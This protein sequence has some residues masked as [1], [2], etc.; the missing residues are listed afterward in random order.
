MCPRE[1]DPVATAT[2][3]CAVCGGVIGVYEPLIHV[4]SGIA[5]RTSRAA[6]PELARTQPGACYHVGCSH[7]SDGAIVSVE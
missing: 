6:D 5:H 3:R 4:A 7:V 1:R 2:L